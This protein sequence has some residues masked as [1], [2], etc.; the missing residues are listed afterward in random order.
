MVVMS[1]TTMVSSTMLAS[2]P[3]PSTDQPMRQVKPTFRIAFVLSTMSAS[4]RPA[5]EDD[6][7]DCFNL[8]TM[9]ASDPDHPRSNETGK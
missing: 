6:I 5:G 3:R 2:G 9:I 8:Y 7:E 4:P 1:G